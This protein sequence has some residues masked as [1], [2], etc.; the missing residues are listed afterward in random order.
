MDLLSLFRGQK[1]NTASI[2]KERL[3]VI[4]AHQRA[5]RT[6]PEWLPKLQQELLDVVRRYV[7]IDEDAVQ[8]ETERDETADI[9]LL[10]LNITLP[11]SR[12]N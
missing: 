11:E 5:G 8:I 12:P 6:G 10:R 7:Q 3:Q 9:E 1:K 4:V 2:A